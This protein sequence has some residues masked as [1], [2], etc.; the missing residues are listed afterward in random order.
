MALSSVPGYGSAYKGYVPAGLNAAQTAAAKKLLAPATPQAQLPGQLP[1]GSLSDYQDRFFPTPVSTVPTTPS[2]DTNNNGNG[3]VPPLTAP[4]S[5]DPSFEDM[6]KGDPLYGGAEAAYNSTLARG[7]AGL[8]EQIQNAVLSSGFTDLGNYMTGRLSNYSGDI[9]PATITAAMQNPFSTK[10]LLEQILGRNTRGVGYDLAARGTLRSGALNNRTNMLQQR[11]GQDTYTQMQSLLAALRGGIDQFG[12][13]SDSAFAAWQNARAAIAARLAQ[14]PGAVPKD[15]PSGPQPPTTNP[16]ADIPGNPYNAP[17]PG[18]GNQFGSLDPGLGA[19]INAG[20]GIFSGGTPPPTN[21]ENPIANIPGNPYGAATEPGAG[22]LYGTLDPGLASGILSG[23]GQN[24]LGEFGFTPSTPTPSAPPP[25]FTGSAPVTDPNAGF[26][27]GDFLTPQ[28]AP[29]AF[30]S[31]P[32]PS[33]P[34]PPA[35]PPVA[36]NT[37][38]GML[39]PETTVPA[40]PAPAAPPPPQVVRVGT[41][42][43]VYYYNAATGQYQWIPDEQTFFGMGLNWGDVQSVGSLAAP[44]GGQLGSGG[45]PPAQAAPTQAAPAPD[46]TDAL[47]RYI[48]NRA[49][50]HPMMV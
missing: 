1:G 36:P 50:T 24:N 2:V 11:F 47:S 37:G 28:T 6:I 41:D 5:S 30:M 13:L 39:N 43:A 10:A 4:T 27:A 26:A 9:D 29:P 18:E 17:P 35:P 7:R 19:G 49:S 8:Q 42:A 3:G 33:T 25:D 22:N 38:Y 34:V 23:A 15:D 14:T 21:Y 40:S 44:V 48:A 46:T 31:P 32:P 12:N 20:D 45:S 16:V